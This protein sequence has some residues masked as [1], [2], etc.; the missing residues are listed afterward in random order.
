MLGPP[1]GDARRVVISVLAFAAAWIVA[2]SGAR[3]GAWILNRQER[4]L[5]NDDS[6]SVIAGLSG[7]RRRSR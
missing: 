4:R 3:I 6:T 2:R 1:S 5:E 7:A